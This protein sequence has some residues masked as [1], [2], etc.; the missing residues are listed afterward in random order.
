MAQDHLSRCARFSNA[1]RRQHIF[2]SVY[3][4]DDNVTLR[5]VLRRCKRIVCTEPALYSGQH[6]LSHG[7]C[8]IAERCWLQII[9][10]RSTGQRAINLPLNWTLYRTDEHPHRGRC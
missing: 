6:L 1:N 10:G 9:P 5:C 3:R 7:F 2:I 8:G 4:H